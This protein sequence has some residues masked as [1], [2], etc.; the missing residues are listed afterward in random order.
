MAAHFDQDGA[1]AVV[2][3]LAE[4]ENVAKALGDQGAAAEAAAVAERVE[5][6]R[7]FVACVGQFKRGKSTL[8]DALLGEPVL[9]AGV[10]PV[11]SVPTVVR[12]GPHRLAR[13][14]TRGGEWK[15]IAVAAIDEYVS[16]ECNPSNGKA[17]TGVEVLYPSPILAT[18]LCLIDTPGLGSVFEANTQATLGFVPHIDVALVVIGADPPISG[19]ELRLIDAVGQHVSE[20]VVVLNKADRAT[21]D[22]RAAACAF[23][24]RV[25]A[26]RLGRAVDEIYEVSAR[27]QLEQSRHWPD[28]DRLVSALEGLSKQAGCAIAASAGRRAVVRLSDRLRTNIARTIVALTEPA[29][30]VEVEIARLTSLIADAERRLDELSPILAAHE[31]KFASAFAEQASSFLRLARPDAHA[32]LD[33]R[34]RDIPAFGPR[35]RRYAMSHA[36]DVAAATIGAWQPLAEREAIA[37]LDQSTRRFAEASEEFLRTTRECGI[38]E[39]RVLPDLEDIRAM[40]AGASRF[41]FNEQI[42][43]AQ[44]ASPLRYLADAVLAAVGRRGALIADAH[45]FLD[46]LLELNVG[47]IESDLA[48]R[49]R[50]GRQDLERSLRAA[51]TGIRDRVAKALTDARHIRDEGAAAVERELDRLAAIRIRLGS[52]SRDHSAG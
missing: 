21:K 4:L 13:V 16:E 33:A 22:E 28:W 19:E 6:G 15:T 12:Y 7:Y 25:V 24:R 34:L 37:I 42:T 44:P 18:G 48:D 40:I 35:A 41:R 2:R 27:D 10:T 8:I 51:V 14:K 1:S 23:A 36:Q 50:Q 39:L 47:R 29:D 26:D 43:T 46:W 11:T 17:I 52:L 45:R 3:R 32:T 5:H 9:P 38:A 20:L 49:V 30:L 31:R